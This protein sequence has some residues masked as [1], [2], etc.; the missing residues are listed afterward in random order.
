LSAVRNTKNKTEKEEAGGSTLSQ[1]D[2]GEETKA[3]KAEVE[4]LKKKN[5]QLRKEKAEGSMPSKNDPNPSQETK[6]SQTDTETKTAETKTETETKTKGAFMKGFA[7]GISAESDLQATLSFNPDLGQGSGKERPSEE[8]RNGTVTDGNRTSSAESEMDKTLNAMKIQTEHQQNMKELFSLTPGA[9]V[10]GPKMVSKVCRNENKA[11]ACRQ[12]G[13][14]WQGSRCKDATRS[15]CASNKKLLHCFLYKTPSPYKVRPIGF[16][17]YAAPQGFTAELQ[18]FCGKQFLGQKSSPV[19]VCKYGY[20]L[21][22]QCE[23]DEDCPCT[24]DE[25]SPNEGVPALFNLITKKKCK[26]TSSGRWVAPC[27]KGSAVEGCYSELI[28]SC[29]DTELNTIPAML[30]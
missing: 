7:H 28:R 15:S 25:H 20:S 23:I 4:Q 17:E 5:A 30:I 19:S 1:N 13:C 6:A 24:M 10:S 29:T 8:Q 27:Y 12:K 18:R 14:V 16:F 2:P 26:K 21:G 22:Q 11:S 9:Q 3:L